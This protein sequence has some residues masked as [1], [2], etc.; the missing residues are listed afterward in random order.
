MPNIKVTLHSIAS[1]TQLL[2]MWSFP[3]STVL[4]PFYSP[5]YIHTASTQFSFNLAHQYSISFCPAKPLYSHPKH[6]CLVYKTKRLNSIL[7]F[8]MCE[9]L[10]YIYCTVLAD[11]T[12]GSDWCAIVAT[13]LCFVLVHL[14]F[15]FRIPSSLFIFLYCSILFLCK[16]LHLWIPLFI[17]W[18]FHMYQNF[19]PLCT[20]LSLTS[21]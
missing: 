6:F 9:M 11:V 7:S 19:P 2:F 14:W 17:N 21:S 15:S 1:Y 4:S 12:Y 8:S 10:H 18:T 3:S 20:A 16:V 13:V 5:S